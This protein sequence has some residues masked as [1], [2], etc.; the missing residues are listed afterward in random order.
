MSA[1]TQSTE[2]MP[3]SVRDVSVRDFPRGSDDY[4]EKKRWSTRLSAVVLVT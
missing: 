1:L 2:V 3:V 4:N